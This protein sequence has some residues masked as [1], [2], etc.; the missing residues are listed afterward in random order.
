MEPM[1]TKL[2]QLPKEV[3]GYAMLTE[4][5]WL[6][7]E[8]HFRVS[9]YRAGLTNKRFSYISIFSLNEVFDQFQP[10]EEMNFSYSKM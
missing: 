8:N 9:A 1:L 3:C 2:T 7:Q 5:T 10:T 4:L 6:T